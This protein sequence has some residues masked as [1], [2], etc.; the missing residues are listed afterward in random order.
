MTTSSTHRVVRVLRAQPRAPPTLRRRR[1]RRSPRVPRAT[2][3]VG[4]LGLVLHDEHPSRTEMLRARRPR[5][6]FTLQHVEGRHHVGRSAGPAGRH[7]RAEE[8][9]ASGEHAGHP[10]RPH[11]TR[12]RRR[13]RRRLDGEAARHGSEQSCSIEASSS[14]PLTSSH[15]PA[16]PRY[17][18]PAGRRYHRAIRRARISRSRTRAAGPALQ[19][20]VGAARHPVQE[21]H[22]RQPAAGPG[23]G[24]R[25]TRTRPSGRYRSRRHV[26]DADHPA[27]AALRTRAQRRRRPGRE[28]ARLHQRVHPGGAG[29]HERG[30]ETAVAVSGGDGPHGRRT[31][32]TRCRSAGD[33]VSPVGHRWWDRRSSTTAAKA[34]LRRRRSSRRDASAPHPAATANRGP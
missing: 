23:G 10:H 26:T 34:R 20:V 22:D 12:P 2:E 19:P 3:Q 14:W 1:R 13:P 25:T 33:D 27:R 16:G 15:P 24:V 11:R 29:D 17:G 28:A 8:R 21:H 31:R 9:I 18:R 5:P 30:A 32:S 6:S 4:H 7:L